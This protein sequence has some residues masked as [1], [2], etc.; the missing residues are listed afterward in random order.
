MF[1]SKLHGTYNDIIGVLFK[2]KKCCY[3]RNKI[4]YK[5]IMPAEFIQ[6]AFSKWRETEATS[7]TR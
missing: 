2:V 4:V 1:I 6:L 7:W 5:Q 3:M